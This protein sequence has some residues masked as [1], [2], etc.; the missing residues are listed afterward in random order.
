M[1]IHV[2]LLKIISYILKQTNN[3]AASKRLSFPVSQAS[4][5]TMNKVWKSAYSSSVTEPPFY[6]LLFTIITIHHSNN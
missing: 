6:I 3:S 2:L 4:N 5:G 1:I